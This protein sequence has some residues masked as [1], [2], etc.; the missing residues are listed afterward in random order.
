[1]KQNQ[2]LLAV[3]FVFFAF[4]AF[5][6]FAFAEDDDPGE[7][8]AVIEEEVEEECEGLQITDNIILNGLLEFDA[9]WGTTN[10][11][12]GSDETESDLVLATAELDITA[13]FT[14]RVTALLVFLW[15]ENYTEPVD[16]DTAAIVYNGNGWR[17]TGGRFYIPF[18]DLTYWF[19]TYPLTADLAETRKTAA[20]IAFFPPEENFEC[21]LT[22]FNGDVDTGEKKNRIDDFVIAAYASNE[23][24]TGCFTFG[25]SYLND[26][27]EAG[28]DLTGYQE[29]FPDGGMV[30]EVPGWGIYA[31]VE[32][33]NYGFSVEYITA[34]GS[35]DTDDLADIDGNPARPSVWN[36]ELMVPTKHGPELA[37]RYG[38]S[39]DCWDFPE[40]MYG[41]GASWGLDDYTTFTLE[42]VHGDFDAGFSEEVSDSDTLTAQLAFAF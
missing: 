30:K 8:A 35:F 19:V 24:D 28:G 41:V 7:D 32:D 21:S 15:E 6:S 22:I 25:A 18:G 20:Q 26:I 34:A 33:E 12:D 10:L 36:L 29:E 13:E 31:T 2:F 14:E 39:N 37:F 17:F 40:M 42:Y 3:L 5:G 1:M 38:G 9:Y 27:A 4:V 16:I 11:Q 23:Y